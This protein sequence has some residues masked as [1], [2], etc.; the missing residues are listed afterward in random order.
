MWDSSV[1]THGIPAESYDVTWRYSKRTVG[2]RIDLVADPGWLAD[3]ERV[4]PVR[5]D[6]TAIAAEGNLSTFDGDA[7]VKN[8]APT[9]N[10]GHDYQGTYP[11]G[12]D[13]LEVG[14][15]PVHGSNA[16]VLRPY[17]DDFLTDLNANDMR[18]TD[19]Q[20][21]MW[22]YYRYE[23]SGGSSRVDIKRSWKHFSEDTITWNWFQTYMVDSGSLT[24]LGEHDMASVNAT[25][26][27]QVGDTIQYWAD[28]WP[29]ADK[30]GALELSCP[31]SSGNSEAEFEGWWDQDHYPIMTIRYTPAPEVKLAAPLSDTPV[32]GTPL[33]RWSY[34]HEF[35]QADGTTLSTPQ[36]RIEVQA[37]Q[38]GTGTICT[39]SIDTTG[40]SA[41]ITLPPSAAW[42]DGQR[43]RVRIR[44]AGKDTS[45]AALA[46]SDWT[47]WTAF[48]YLSDPGS[49]R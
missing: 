38:E 32:S 29:D 11:N 43:Y 35:E 42:S 34:T 27:W 28:N 5:I 13:R 48:T 7:Y 33:V 6:P 20:L 36:T 37:G 21:K 1:S 26:T 18:V 23:G 44:A 14:Y 15:S 2:W 49:V 45:G 12:H 4:Y 3:P 17:I 16:I 19:A 24:D 47:E 10:F 25:S 41:V 40:S 22:C 39:S 46:W 9:T 8:T 30:S 31:S